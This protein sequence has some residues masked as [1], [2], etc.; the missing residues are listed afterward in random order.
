MRTTRLLG[1]MCCESP[2]EHYRIIDEEVRA[3][4]HRAEGSPAP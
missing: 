1:G 3:P 4:E 2:I